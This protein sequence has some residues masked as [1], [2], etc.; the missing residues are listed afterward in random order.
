MSL[1]AM[2]LP[3]IWRRLCGRT[4]AGDY[5]LSPAGPAATTAAASA[6]SRTGEYLRTDCAPHLEPSLRPDGTIVLELVRVI[7][8]LPLPPGVCAPPR[9][10]FPSVV[11]GQLVDLPSPGPAGGALVA[12]A[13]VGPAQRSADVNAGSV[14]SVV[15]GWPYVV[16]PELL[17]CSRRQTAGAPPQQSAPARLPFPAPLGRVSYGWSTGS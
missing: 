14:Q 3:A 11:Q 2:R 13:P 4:G 16:P 6:S 5:V 10:G 9:R 12:W 17:Y 8:A 1:Q 7:A 15:S